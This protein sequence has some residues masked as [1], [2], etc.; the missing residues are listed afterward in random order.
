VLRQNGIFEEKKKE[1]CTWEKRE[2][3]KVSWIYV[4]ILFFCSNFFWRRWL[5]DVMVVCFGGRPR[6]FQIGFL[7]CDLGVCLGSKYGKSHRAV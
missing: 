2:E 5:L 1:N 4:I 3:K 6:G 7:F